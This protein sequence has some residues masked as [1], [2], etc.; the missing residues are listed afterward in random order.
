MKTRQGFFAHPVYL[1]QQST[2]YIPITMKFYIDK[3][4]TFLEKNILKLENLE[5]INNVLRDPVNILFN[6]LFQ[7]ACRR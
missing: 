2:N 6:I 4:Y 5:K 7:I 3:P 1:S